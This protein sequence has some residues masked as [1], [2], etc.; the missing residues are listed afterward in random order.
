MKTKTLLQ[1]LLI[2]VFLNIIFVLNLSFD[3]KWI[4]F[5]EPK[6]QISAKNSNDNQVELESTEELYFLKTFL[7]KWF[8]F[9]SENAI[10]HF[11]ELAFLTNSETLANQLS[12]KKRLCQK[13]KN[14]KFEQ[15]ADILSIENLKNQN[16][17]VWLKIQLK[18]NE[19][20]LQFF[21]SADI[22]IKKT[23]RSANNL[24]GLLVNELS[25]KT[26]PAAEIPNELYLQPLR[27][28]QIY[29]PCLVQTISNSHPDSLKLKLTNSEKSNAE[30]WLQSTKQE[31]FNLSFF[32]ENEQFDFKFKP[33]TANSLVFLLAEKKFSKTISKS[34]TPKKK[35]PTE[36]SS[37]LLNEL[38]FEVDQ[39]TKQTN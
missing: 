12:E 7:E 21:V 38:G 19:K 29:F 11:E 18:E 2:S 31:D 13:I 17:R 6:N 20:T 36:Y 27:H 8:N 34:P 9:S 14:Q 4:L 30:I 28:T 37:P 5:S 23:E 35:K 39:G 26:A 24:W 16:F 10:T 3:K 22:K 1:L 33:A 32:C 25:L 15:S